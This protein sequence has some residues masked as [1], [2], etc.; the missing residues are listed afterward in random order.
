M[1]NAMNIVWAF[2]VEKARD[3]AGNVIDPNMAEFSDVRILH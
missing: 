2:N 3:S 1:I